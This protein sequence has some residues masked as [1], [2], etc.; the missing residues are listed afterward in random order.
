MKIPRQYI[1]KSKP[2]AIPNTNG[3][4]LP[5]LDLNAAP[6]ECVPGKGI[7]AWTCDGPGKPI[8][9]HPY[10]VIRSRAAQLTGRRHDEPWFTTA[11]MQYSNRGLRGP[12]V[13]QKTQDVEEAA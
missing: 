5:G 3:I 2:S 13:Q 9:D 12:K 1:R 6:I 10:S 7:P 8:V 11:A 4:T